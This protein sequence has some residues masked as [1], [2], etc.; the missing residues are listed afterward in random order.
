MSR[1]A[2]LRTNKCNINLIT[3][4]RVLLFLLL[5]LYN[6]YYYYYYYYRYYYYYLLCVQLVS[7]SYP[8][9]TACRCLHGTVFQSMF[10]NDPVVE[11]AV[12]LEDKM[13]S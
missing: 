10:S 1:T 9:E 8:D 7:L 11:P 12:S 2:S 5:L 4:C 3:I 13:G 6:H